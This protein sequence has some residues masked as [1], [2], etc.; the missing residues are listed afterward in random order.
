MSLSAMRTHLLSQATAIP[1]SSCANSGNSFF[2][3]VG[4]E[5]PPLPLPT[6][7]SINPNFGPTSG[8]TSVTISGSNLTS[9]TSVTFDGIGMT[10]LTV[11]NSAT[12]TGFT[13]TGSIG[14]ATLVVTT[15]IGTNSAANLFTYVGTAAFLTVT[16]LFPPDRGTFADPLSNIGSNFAPVTGS[17]YIVYGGKTFYSELSKGS[18]N[19]YLYQNDGTLVETLTAAQLNISN[20]VVELP[21]ADREFGTDYYILMDQ[22]VIR[23]CNSENVAI[24]T[25]GAW[26]FNTPAFATDP[27]SVESTPFTPMPSIVP[28]LT[29]TTLN[30]YVLTLS[31]NTDITKGTGDLAIYKASD[32]SLVL[33]VPVADTTVIGPVLTFPTFQD[34]LENGET[35]Y[36][37]ANSG[38]IKSYVAIDCF[39]SETPADNLIT[40]EFTLPVAFQL[41][42]F[43][44]DSTP[45]ANNLEK[46]NPQTNIALIFNKN[47]SFTNTGTITIFNSSGAVHQAINVTTNFNA[48]RTNELIWIGDDPTT[49]TFTTNTLWINPTKD[50]LLGET[51]YVLATPTCVRSVQLE[52]WTGLSNENTVRFTVDPGP[53]ATVPTP[54]NDSDNIS[55][56]FDREVELSTGEIFI[57]DENGTV[58]A[59]IPAD[60]PAVSLV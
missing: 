32:D 20:N 12:I 15:P 6:I 24:T 3:Y 46:V 35:Y 45:F 42:K 17:Y 39:F 22:G 4:A 54:D 21:F 13:P 34:V 26:N 36:V 33:T 49:S 29:Q 51:Y 27:Y 47:I 53:I 55:L 19:V 37:T 43:F 58:L 7:T 30:G 57:T 10:G 41:V 14:P 9:A 5:Q 2:T 48:N 11:V 28:T 25:G 16:Q 18:G 8:G 52:N 59:T 23:Y 31:F 56:T 44:V 60:D 50:L 40:S 1:H 38:Y